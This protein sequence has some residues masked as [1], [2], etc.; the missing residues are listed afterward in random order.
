MSSEHRN[1]ATPDRSMAVGEPDGFSLD[2]EVRQR[3]RSARHLH[4][5]GQ[6]RRAKLGYVLAL[7]ACPVNCE[8][9]VGLAQLHVLE[10]RLPAALKVLL[11]APDGTV[12]SAEYHYLLGCIY[13]QQGDLDLTRRHFAKALELADDF[14]EI[15]EFMAR[16]QLPGPV[17]RD[18]L[19]TL[20]GRL[21]PSVYVEIGVAWGDTFALSGDSRLSIGI[22]PVPRLRSPLL[23]NMQLFSVP[24]D[25]FFASPENRRL[26]EDNPIDMCFVDGLHEFSQA[27]RDIFNA[28]AFA[29]PGSVI[30]VHDAYPL[31]QATSTP[32][33]RTMFWSGDVWKAIVALRQSCPDLRIETLACPP[34]GLSVITNLDP[35]R[36][37]GRPRIDAIAER[38][39]SLTYDDI[40]Q[41]KAECLSMVCDWQAV[42]DRLAPRPAPG[43]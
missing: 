2:H 43:P 32:E 15:H 4:L 36:K 34:T 13:Q 26:L 9:R 1:A 42:L 33:R 24:S 10:D 12:L 41:T 7:E 21:K 30:L 25:T 27:L 5:T 14:Q 22:D 6:A 28:E 19:A 18:F 31:N 35:G 40:A 16:E 11:S 17:Y 37:L 39:G 8:T 29:K 20:H 23:A 3:L 38:F